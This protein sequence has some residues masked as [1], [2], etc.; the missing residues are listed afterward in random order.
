MLRSPISTHQLGP[1]TKI[2]RYKEP[3]SNRP[4]RGLIILVA[5]L[6]DSA[7]TDTHNRMTRA[8]D[9]ESSCR[10]GTTCHYRSLLY[11]FKRLTPVSA[12]RSY[13]FE[14]IVSYSSGKVVAK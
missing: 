8:E 6:T 5:R 3:Q 10:S 12:G 2:N 9:F 4:T 1:N 11:L 13:R 14:H 7:R